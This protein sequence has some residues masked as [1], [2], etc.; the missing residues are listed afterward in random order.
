MRPSF[1]LSVFGSYTGTTAEGI[2][3]GSNNSDLRKYYKNRITSFEDEYMKREIYAFA[4]S[5]MSFLYEKGKVQS[6]T[7]ESHKSEDVI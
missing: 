7:I 4:K 1:A 5:F 3:I 2:G 6:I